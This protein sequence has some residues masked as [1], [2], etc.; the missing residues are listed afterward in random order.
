MNINIRCPLNGFL[1]YG[2]VSINIVKFLT[3]LGYEVSLFPI[4]NIQLTTNDVTIIQKCLENAHQFVYDAPSI[5]IWH[6]HDMSCFPGNGRKT[7]LSFFE[8]DKFDTIRIHQ[9]LYCDDYIAPSSW[10]KKILIEQLQPVEDQFTEFT[11]DL[12]SHIKVIPMGVDT[13]IFKPY[14][15]KHPSITSKVPTFLN[16]GKIEVRKG[17]DLIPDLFTKALPNQDYKLYMMW[18]NPFLSQ[19]EVNKWE[20][21][22]RAKL[23]DKVE[24]LPQVRTDI[25][26][27]QIMSDVDCAI[28]PTRVEGFGLPILQSMA[29]GT[30]VISTNYGAQSEFVNEENCH[31]VNITQKESAFDG[32]WF[33]GDFQWG[34]IGN[35]EQ[36]QIVEHIR[37]VY[38]DKLEQR[39]TKGLETAKKFSWE[40]TVQKIVK[41]IGSK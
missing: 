25:E 31:L 20:D 39:K 22:Y 21:L 7:G 29:C 38:N 15:Q 9:L 34:Y 11:R 5:L 40:N 16:V 3:K 30:Q 2:H 33:F 28:F 12:D 36:D 19:Q 24:F 6:E 23:G 37:T 17:H 1:G 26:L 41:F 10:A 4:G 27:A 8:R 35:K 32:K 14:V 13:D 18:S